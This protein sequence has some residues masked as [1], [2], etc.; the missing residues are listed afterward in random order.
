MKIRIEKELKSNKGLLAVPMGQEDV[1]EKKHK[2]KGVEKLLSNLKP[3]KNFNGKPLQK[4]STLLSGK[5]DPEVALFVGVGEEKEMNAKLARDIG[6]EIGKFAKSEG[7]KEISIILEKELDMFIRELVEGILSSQYDIGKLKAKRKKEEEYELSVLN[8]ITPKPSRAFK[9][10]VKKAQT[11]ADALSYVKDLVNFPSNIV[12]ARYMAIEAKKIAKSNGYKVA[13]FGE[14]ELKKMGWGGL[15]SVN[16]GTKKEARC[17]VLQ[18]DGAKDKKQKP[19]ALVG[20]GMIFDTGGYSMKS[21]SGMADMHQDMAGGA[22][23][24]GVFSALKKLGI[25]K[26]VIGVVPLG[27][28]LVSDTSYRPSDIITMLSRD[29]VEITN[30]D[31]EGRLILAD[32]ITYVTSLS[33][34]KIITIATLTGAVRV[35]TGE[36]YAGLITNNNSLAE[37]LKSAGE[38]VDD[39]GWQLPLD[40]DYRKSV[41]SKIA[42]MQNY[43]AKMGSSAGSSRA[44][45]FL[46]AFT[47]KHDWCHIDIGGTAFTTSPKPYQTPGATGHGLGMLLAYLEN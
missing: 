33:P 10:H 9:E 4:M 27:E 29:T 14:K 34:S 17:V 41:K 39:L 38:K 31:A 42:D 35:A 25:K 5:Q 1:K 16:D 36:R 28:N 13:V 12:D 26:N 47:E 40:D 30:T 11:T 23:V 37:E 24:L 45:G 22:T 15:L 18:Y 6:G 2:N 3:L 7:L 46:E 44:A 21:S 19:I 32:A 20:K 8:L 43:D